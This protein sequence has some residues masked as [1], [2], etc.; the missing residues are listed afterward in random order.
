MVNN[1]CE[2]LVFGLIEQNLVT[3]L[4]MHLDGAHFLGK[5]LARSLYQSLAEVGGKLPTDVPMLAAI[6]LAALRSIDPG[7]NIP[8]CPSVS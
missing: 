4:Q 7:M 3:C 6:S 8:A 1:N 2:L 5:V